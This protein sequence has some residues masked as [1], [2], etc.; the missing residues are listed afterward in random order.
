MKTVK[1][2]SRISGVSVRTLHHYDAIGLLKPTEL[3]EAGYRLYDE[4][5][6]Q[7]LHTILMFRELRFPLKEI[8]EMLDSPMFDPAEALDKQIR[9]LEMQKE[10]T[11][12]LIKIAKELRAKGEIAM[13]F[14]AFDHAEQEKYRREV[15]ERWGNTEAY[16]EFEKKTP[17]ADAGQGLMELLGQLGKLRPL[18]AND[19]KVKAKVRQLQAYITKNFYTCTDEILLSLGEMYVSDGRF[20]KN[21]DACG[22][23]GAA[24]YIREA[25]IQTVK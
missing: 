15:K 25:I 1:D 9:L 20:T 24:Q 5:S 17:A 22:G 18:P 2:M 7:R 14:D 21:I 13:N 3:T 8:K 12:Q 6:L 11:E 4:Q 23:D 16:R 19:E 10:H